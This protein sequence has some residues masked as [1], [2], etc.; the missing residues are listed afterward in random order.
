LVPANPIPTN[1]KITAL[2]GNDY[3][4]LKFYK[5]TAGIIQLIPDITAP[6]DTLYYQDGTSP[7]KVGIIKI[8]ESNLTNT[9]NVETDILGRIN[10][11]SEN[12]VEFT[13][14]LKVS[15]DGDVIPRSYLEGE[16]YVEGV[17]SAISLI[18]V[19]NLIAPE[20]F[21]FDSSIPYDIL[22]YDIG[23]YD[24]SLFIPLIPDYITIS[25]N[26]INRNPWSRSNRWFHIDVIRATSNYNNDPDILND[27]ATADAKAKRPIIEFYP[28]LKL[29][30][31]GTF[32]KDPID[33][34]DFRTTDA[35]SY[36]AGQENYYPDVQ[37]YTAYTATINGVTGGTTTTITVPAND[38]TGTFVIGQ[39]ITDI[40]FPVN[41]AVTNVLPANAVI[42]DITGTTT[43]TLTVVWND[44]TTFST[45]TNSSLIANDENNPNYILFPGARVVF[46]AD[47]NEEVKNKIYV[48]NF[49]TVGTG[50][51]PVITLTE[52]PDGQILINDQVVSFR[53]FNNQGKS[54]Y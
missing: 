46:A 44:V 50:S 23:N 6:L 1:Q 40:P 39:Y 34:I 33:F 41:P 11:T 28:N 12:G 10:F 24:S 14:G 8:I 53:G 45:V 16:Y 22:P 18:P 43:L 54:F 21:T 47:T 29:Y 15:F 30:Q 27:F 25:R 9:L 3:V 52:A 36:V 35:L 4:G 13:N 48:V 26:A 31:S 19:Q 20:D 37:V 2:F 17:G 5:N 49:S 51:N 42:T 7:N 38:V 32:G